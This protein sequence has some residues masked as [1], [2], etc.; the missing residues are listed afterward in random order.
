MVSNKFYF[1]FIVIFS[2]IVDTCYW[3]M[4]WKSSTGFSLVEILCLMYHLVTGLVDVNLLKS[5]RGFAFCAILCDG[6]YDFSFKWL[7]LFWWLWDGI[8]SIHFHRRRKSSK[9]VLEISYFW[10]TEVS[11]VFQCSLLYFQNIW[12]DREKNQELSKRNSKIMERNKIYT[13]QATESNT[14]IFQWITWMSSHECTLKD[15]EPW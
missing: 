8:K 15:F 6:I 12:T 10:T 5:K 2:S 13:S 1:G 4:S 7:F 11:R 9:N 14:F 3:G